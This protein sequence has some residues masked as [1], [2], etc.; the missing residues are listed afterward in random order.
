M[1]LVMLTGLQLANRRSAL[2]AAL[3]CVL[4]APASARA[5]SIT[6]KNET[7]IPLIVQ[8]TTI[9]P[10]FVR[11]RPYL[12]KPGESTAGITLPG[13]KTVYIFHTGA[14]NRLLGR[15]MVSASPDNLYFA[16]IADTPPP[17]LKLDARPT[18]TRPKP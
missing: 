1:V 2:R 18:P 17:K 10:L 12:L 7:K 8:A 13:N 6:I 4:L 11:D 15:P 5:G 9:A 16:I 3:C 14:G